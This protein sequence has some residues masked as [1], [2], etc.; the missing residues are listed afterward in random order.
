MVV[1]LLSLTLACYPAQAVAP[2]VLIAKQIVKQIIFDFVEARIEDGIRASFGPCKADLA[3]DAVKQSRTLTGLLRGSGGSGLANLGALGNAGNLGSLSQLGAAGGQA[4]TVR[5]LQN[6]QLTADSV[7]SA[8]NLVGGVGGGD[9]ALAVGQIAG[10]VSG[11]AG[12][13]GSA[14]SVSGA[15]GAAGA[16]GV[17]NVAGVGGAGGMGALL[18]A[19]MTAAMSQM[20]P[21]GAGM[22]GIGGADMQQAMAMMQQMMNAKPLDAA[23]LNELALILESFGKI[24]EAIQPGSACSADDYRRQFM[25]MTAMSAQP[26]MPQAGAMMNGVMRMMYTSF[27]DMQRSTAEAEK[28]FL[29]MNAEERVEYVQ[30]TMAEM[31]DQPPE[32]RRAFLAMID[33][34]MLGMPADM[35]DAFRKQLAS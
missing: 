24:S 13:A 21:Q 4:R 5:N 6:V 20:V 26:G 12:M 1:V 19:D 22:S 23:E 34:G 8:A 33:A 2:A 32:G 16:L 27:K 10:T 15:A 18:G 35:R 14:A 3:E 28:M 11:A 31:K 29:Q 7:S 17:P 25:R 30:M 9:A